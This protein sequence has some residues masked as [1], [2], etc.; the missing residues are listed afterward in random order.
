M[1]KALYLL[2][3]ALVKL[4]REE[5]AKEIEDLAND[6]LNEADV[7]SL[8][9]TNNADWKDGE[10]APSYLRKKAG[11][12]FVIRHW[13][14]IEEKFGE[15]GVEAKRLW[16]DFVSTDS[17]GQYDNSVSSYISFYRN[18]ENLNNENKDLYLKFKSL[19]K[20]PEKKIVEEEAKEE[21]E[22]ST[23]Y[24][25]KPINQTMTNFSYEESDEMYKR[26]L[27]GVG[28]PVTQ[29]NITYMRAWRRAEGGKAT[30]N[31][32]N[33]TQKYQ[34]ATNY[35]SV[36]VKNYPTMEAG[37]EATV[38]TLLNGRYN[39]IVDSL[40][41]DSPPQ[42][43]AASKSLSVWGTGG[44]VLSV[45]SRSQAKRSPGVLERVGDA[46][47]S[48][49]AFAKH[50]LGGTKVGWSEKGGYAGGPSDHASRRRGNWQSDNA[51]DLAAPEGTPVYSITTGKV[52]KVKQSTPSKDGK[53]YGISVTVDG[54]STFP[55]IFYTH[56]GSATVSVGEE[57]K[58]GQQIGTI[59]ASSDP[60][61]PRH[62]H[63]GLESGHISSYI[64]ESGDIK[65]A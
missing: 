53:V 60:T 62:V 49:K 23:G 38:K 20:R 63:I 17:S 44:G 55:S 52:V 18:K 12:I 13:N 30:F 61:M 39:D 26:I 5:A 9:E 27:K 54:G 48:G 16:D 42:V 33:T 21:V 8:I 2:K 29:N 46:L 65:M 25:S 58:F 50:V 37:I 34:G 22:Q 47:K 41:S 1:R 10:S 36:G 4:S 40:K 45:L 56:L 15:N 51:W 35:N 19:M 14:Q 59:G 28:A 11:E 43:T 32:F 57:V 6:L 3:T 31:P 24:T 7:L 64:T